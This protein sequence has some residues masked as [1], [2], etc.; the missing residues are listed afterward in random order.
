MRIAVIQITSVQDPEI[1]LKKIQGFIDKA[2]QEM[3]IEAIF[4]PEVFYSMSNGEEATP[5]LI[6][7]DNEH[8]KNIQK[9]AKDNDVYLLGATAAT[10][11][12][13]GGK[14]INRNYNFGPDGVELDHY[15]KMHLFRV[16]LSRHSSKTVIDESIVYKSGD[17]PKLLNIKDWKIGLS[18]CF[19]LRF[20]EL[21]RHYFLQGANLLT[22]ASAFTVPTGKAHWEV[23]LRARAIENQSYVVACN[24]YGTHNDKIKTYGHS[25]VISPWGEVLADLGEKEGFAT[26]ELD[27]EEV[28]KV[29]ARLDVKPRFKN[30]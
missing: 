10:K 25:L 16:D 17:T 27:I 11:D 3:A 28:T 22:V 5:Y 23:L 8:Y 15:D 2:K 30:I 24:Q 13:E 12:P 20:P 7:R 1:N 14:V 19:D 4:L 6:E 26:I 9:L 18:I 29:R 21:Y